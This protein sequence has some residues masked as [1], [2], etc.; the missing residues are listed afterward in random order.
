MAHA[1]GRI[2]ERLE[3]LREACECQP[4]EAALPVLRQALADRH[5]RIVAKAADVTAERLLYALEGALA[6]AYRCFLDDPIRR[7]PQCIAKSAI[8]RA[9]VALDYQDSELYLEGLAYRQME[10]VYGGRQDSAVDLRCSCA[11]GLVGTA[12]SR[13]VVALAELLADPDARARIGAVRGLAC[14]PASQVEAVLRLKA[15]V[16]DEESEV[17][18][19]CFAALLQ[20]EPEL[21]VA[22][23]ARFLEA[24]NPVVQELAALALGS[25]QARESFEALRQVWEMPMLSLEWRQVLLRAVALCRSEAAVEWLL[26]IV[27]EANDWPSIAMTSSC[28]NVCER[29]WKDGGIRG[30]EVSSRRYG[31]MN[32]ACSLPI[33]MC[34]CGTRLWIPRG[35]Y[36]ETYP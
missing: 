26:S 8:V 34:S 1:R 31:A 27:A 36:G 12:Y 4:G 3:A 2:E 16:G 22:F 13:A 29:W 21:S 35:R 25:S 28:A 10:P 5:Y 30:W 18:G 17:V 24:A 9:L 14:L 33:L 23:V 6:D 32:R 7:D 20:V 19:E 15:L 11:M